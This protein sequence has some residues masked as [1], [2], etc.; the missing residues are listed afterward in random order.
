MVSGGG[1]SAIWPAAPP[2]PA[3]LWISRRWRISSRA[4]RV[5]LLKNFLPRSLE[6]LLLILVIADLLLS[7]TRSSYLDP[8]ETTRICGERVRDFIYPS[9]FIFH[10]PS[11]VAGLLACLNGERNMCISKKRV[12]ISK[13]GGKKKGK[14]E[15]EILVLWKEEKG[16]QTFE[17]SYV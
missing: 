16:R 8:S 7:S 5:A 14:R 6:H 12:D 11:K 1:H 4:R 2:V 15:R 17:T 3:K 9:I 10:L 13:R